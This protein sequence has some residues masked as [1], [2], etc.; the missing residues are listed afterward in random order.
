MSVTGEALAMRIAVVVVSYNTCDLLRRCLYSVL[1]T[2]LPADAQLQVIVVDNASQDGSAAMVSDDYP[3]VELIASPDNLGFTGGNNLALQ[4]LGFAVSAPP[5]AKH[6][7]TTAPVETPDCVL[8]LNPDAEVQGDAIVRMA[9][10][11]AETPQAGACGGH[12]RYGDG[13]F[14]HG[15]FRFPTLAQVALDFFP[16]TGWPGAHRLH[17]SR[18]NGR[19]PARCWQST[20]PFAVD[21]VLGAAL[22]VRGAAIHQ[23][24]GLDDAYFMYCEEMDWCLRLQEAGWGVYAL[25]TALVIHHEAQSSRQVRWDAYERL[26]RSRLRFYTKH[27]HRYPKGYPTL[28]RGLIRLGAAW[29]SRQARRRFATGRATG[30]E[31]A[32]ELAAYRAVSRL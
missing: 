30:L 18:I 11:L 10:F 13:R 19:Y 26:W 12:L 24:G 1:A 29:H 27:R 20:T 9:R 23:V 16:L 5:I 4:R 8:L 31:T 6:L 17:T 28:V 14:Q 7:T 2:P 21:F 32:R 15:A 22:M 3:T 25:P